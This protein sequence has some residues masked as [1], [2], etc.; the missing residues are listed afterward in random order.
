VYVGL[1]DGDVGGPLD[2]DAALGRPR[3]VVEV[4][5]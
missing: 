4:A 5:A 1:L 2:I 3:P